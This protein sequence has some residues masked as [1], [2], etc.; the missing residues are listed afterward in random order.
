MIISLVGCAASA[1]KESDCQKYV[2]TT[3]VT[4]SNNVKLPSVTGMS[5]KQKKIAIAKFILEAET[6]KYQTM[7]RL[8]LELP[9]SQ[10]LHQKELEANQKYI[11]SLQKQVDVLATLPDQSSEA[12]ID[13]IIAPVKTEISTAFD[14]QPM[15]DFVIYCKDTKIGSQKEK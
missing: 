15:F 6:K 13:K 7:Q 3:A 12:E 14:A 5:I 1:A 11:N 10:K 4:A 8:T 9:E 2:E